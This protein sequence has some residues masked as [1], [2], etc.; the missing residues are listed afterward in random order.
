MIVN[1]CTVLLNINCTF[2]IKVTKYSATHCRDYTRIL[3]NV[4]PH[5]RAHFGVP[6]E[7]FSEKVGETGRKRQSKF[8]PGVAFH[9]ENSVALSRLL[10]G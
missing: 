3:V 2:I 1:V 4:S 7:I 10:A 5:D 9:L 8:E 6:D